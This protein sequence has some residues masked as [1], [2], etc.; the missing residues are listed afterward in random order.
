MRTILRQQFTKDK[1]RTPSDLIRPLIAPRHRKMSGNGER[2]LR[3]RR[4]NIQFKRWHDF[5]SENMNHNLKSLV[6]VTSRNRRTFPD[7]LHIL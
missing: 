7:F 3:N 4:S 5:R 1:Q 6:V 2:A